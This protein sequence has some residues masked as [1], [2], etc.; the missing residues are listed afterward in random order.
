MI[1]II[2][3]LPGSGKSYFAARL[4]AKTGAV[5]ISSDKIRKSLDAL[6]KYTVTDKEAVYRKM[7]EITEKSLAENKTA[8]LDAT[9]YRKPLRDLFSEI[10]RRYGVPLVF[11][12]VKADEGLVKERL[13]K[14]REDSEADESVYYK[15]RDQF[16]EITQPHVCLES[17]ND[18]ITQ[19]LNKATTYIRNNYGRK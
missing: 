3:G 12:L 19:M 8:V 15:I 13:A 10:A 14:P 18:N 9:F 6:S 4:A 11:I 2:A 1:I 7:A 5:H 16:E 17:T